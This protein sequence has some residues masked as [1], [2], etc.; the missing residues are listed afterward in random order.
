MTIKVT[1]KQEEFL[2]LFAKKQSSGMDDNRGTYKPIHIVQNLTWNSTPYSE[3]LENYYDR[4]NLHFSTDDDYDEWFRSEVDVVKNYYRSRNKECPV[5][6][7]SFEEAQYEKIE[8][9]DNNLVGISTYDDY[10]EA[11][12]VPA[13][14]SWR[15]KR[16]ENVAYFFILEEAKKYM[17]YQAHNLNE[18]RVYTAGSGYGNVGEYEHFYSLLQSMGSQLIKE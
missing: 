11:Y 10:F 15:E 14:F 5:E 17:E 9:I 7:K 1:E 8:D 16:Y 13:Y 4:Y 12:N 3:E 6:I 18:P 2:K